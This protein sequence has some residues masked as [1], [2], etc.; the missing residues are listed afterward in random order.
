MA[1]PA[2]IQIVA[3]QYSK[4]PTSKLERDV[5]QGHVVIGQGV[6]ALN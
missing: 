2:V 6:M 5:L 4:G 3:F 1:S